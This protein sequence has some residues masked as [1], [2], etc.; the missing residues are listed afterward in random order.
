MKA[1]A[2]PYEIY[3]RSFCRARLFSLLGGQ[4]PLGAGG[5]SLL[6]GMLV[7]MNRILL[8]KSDAK[9]RRLKKKSERSSIAGG[10]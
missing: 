5:G 8:K 1:S 2:P 6:L 4:L 10:R 3:K 7:F 9:S